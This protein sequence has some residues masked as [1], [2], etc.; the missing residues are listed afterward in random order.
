M[1]LLTQKEASV[2]LGYSPKSS[3]LAQMRMEKYKGKWEFTPRYIE[4]NGTI[5][6][7]LDWLEADL[8]AWREHKLKGA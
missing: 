1:K 7:P 8:K 6:S 2:M 5:R 4:F 3:I